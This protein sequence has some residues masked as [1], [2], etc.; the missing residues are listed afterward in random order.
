MDMA[1]LDQSYSQIKSALNTFKIRSPD[2][3][4][5][6]DQ[7][8]ISSVVGA[9]DGAI[10]SMVAERTGL[11]ARVRAIVD[12][13]QAPAKHRFWQSKAQSD[14]SGE[15]F[16]R[17]EQRLNLLAQQVSELELIKV[18]VLEKFPDAMR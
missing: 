3:E 15:E 18:S 14:L 16:M 1:I 12:Q 17:A 11:I 6:V 4:L 8:R 5:T 10:Q 9:I 2:R 13:P 7:E